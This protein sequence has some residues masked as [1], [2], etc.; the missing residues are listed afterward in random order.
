VHLA[1]ASAAACSCGTATVRVCG[2]CRSCFLARCRS[3]CC[4]CSCICW[5]LVGR[6][7]RPRRA[8]VRLLLLLLCGSTG[9]VAG[10]DGISRAACR[11]YAGL[12]A[13]E[14]AAVAG[15]AWPARACLQERADGHKHRMFGTTSSRVMLSRTVGRKQCNALNN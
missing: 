10:S 11:T 5:L 6:A 8:A 7:R 2:S 12:L 14:H 4:C 1:F 3:C 15:I 9:A 13:S